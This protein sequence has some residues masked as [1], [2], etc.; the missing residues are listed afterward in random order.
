MQPGMNEV[1]VPTGMLVDSRHVMPKVIV[2]DSLEAQEGRYQ[3]DDKL[4]QAHFPGARS[5]ELVFKA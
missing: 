5:I 4:C 1:A 2:F 3:M